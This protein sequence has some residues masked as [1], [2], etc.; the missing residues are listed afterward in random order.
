MHT[1]EGA[2]ACDDCPLALDMLAFCP[3][4]HDAACDIACSGMYD[5]AGKIGVV[6]VQGAY[7][8]VDP[9]LAREADASI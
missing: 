8:T 5:D 4:I 9:L 3:A 1:I 7:V 2:K 6:I